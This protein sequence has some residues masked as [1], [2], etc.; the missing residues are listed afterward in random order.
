MFLLGRRESITP[1]P[2]IRPVKIVA[3]HVKNGRTVI[4]EAGRPLGHTIDEEKLGLELKGA[5][6]RRDGRLYRYHKR[7]HISCD[8]STI[9]T[10]ACSVYSTC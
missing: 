6:H 10:T 9:H 5:G 2:S 4:V 3:R 8:L 7:K 1:N